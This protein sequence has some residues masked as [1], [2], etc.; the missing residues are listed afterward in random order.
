MI[1]S[2]SF[3]GIDKCGNVED[4]KG[5]TAPIKNNLPADAFEGSGSKTE[6]NGTP[7]DAKTKKTTNGFVKLVTNIISRLQ[8]PTP[9]ENKACRDYIAR[10]SGGST[11][12]SEI[13]PKP[14]SQPEPAQMS[15]PD[16]DQAPELFDPEEPQPTVYCDELFDSDEPMPSEPAPNWSPELFDSEDDYFAYIA[17]LS[18]NSK[19]DLEIEP[20][21]TGILLKLMDI[22]VEEDLKTEQSGTPTG[23]AAEESESWEDFVERYVDEVASDAKE[24]LDWAYKQKHPEPEPAQMLEPDPDWCELDPPEW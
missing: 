12:D 2:V 14:N 6:Q 19:T 18:E 24:Y 3:K 4:K 22:P 5:Q 1:G 13:E 23:T 15:E 16:P 20:K 17:A 21:T 9:K 7:T 8:H 11:T 10:L